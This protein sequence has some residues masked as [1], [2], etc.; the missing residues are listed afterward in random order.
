MK[1]RIRILPPLV[2]K[3]IVLR[4]DPQRFGTTDGTEIRG[5]ALLVL[6][7]TIIAALPSHFGEH[8]APEGGGVGG[9]CC[10]AGVFGGDYGHG[11]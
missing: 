2:A 9:P 8:F 1:P 11:W 7:E 6:A 3:R 10:V 5:S 4:P